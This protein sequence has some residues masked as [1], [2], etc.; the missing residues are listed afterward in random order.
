MRVARLI[1]NGV[2]AEKIGAKSPNFDN[3]E[4]RR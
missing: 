3:E 2:P 1:V 4:K